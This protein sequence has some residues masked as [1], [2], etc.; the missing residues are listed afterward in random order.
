M[1]ELAEVVNQLRSELE[2]AQGGAAEE[3]LRFELGP[4]ELEVTVGL[5]KEGGAGAKVRFWV[6]EVGA[7]AKASAMST[8][9]IKLTLH[10]TL[11]G[12]RAEKRIA[13]GS[14]YIAGDEL[15]GER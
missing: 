15:P 4:I 1:I 13:A 14:V 7:E 5:T 10:P 12:L 6:A 8:Q 9:R 2:F 3:E 11:R